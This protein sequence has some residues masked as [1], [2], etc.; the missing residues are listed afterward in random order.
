M[1]GSQAGNRVTNPSAITGIA[2]H[3]QNV[4]TSFNRVVSM[5]AG[6]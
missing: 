5:G 4:N 2:A 6:R 3:G 1:M